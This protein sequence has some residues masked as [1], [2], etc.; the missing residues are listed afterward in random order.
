MQIMKDFFNDN[1][2]MRAFLTSNFCAISQMHQYRY[3]FHLNMQSNH[4]NKIHLTLCTKSWGVENVSFIIGGLHNVLALDST[5]TC[6]SRL[7]I[8]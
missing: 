3:D 4:L 7:T 2:K 1:D 5:S 8:D 6:F